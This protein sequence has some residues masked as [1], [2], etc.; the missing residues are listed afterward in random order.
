MRLLSFLLL[1]LL[2]AFSLVLA[3]DSSAENSTA[4]ANPLAALPVCAQKCLASAVANSTCNPNDVKCTC[5][6]AS[7]QESSAICIAG[8]CTVRE[9]LTTK[10]ATS[11][12]CGVPV[13]NKTPIFA[14]VTIVL[15]VIAGFIV[16]LRIGSKIGL[17]LG[18]AS[19]DYAILV[20]LACGIPSSVMNVRGTGGNGEG[21]DIWTLPF[22]MI[23]RFGVYFYT[24]EIL[25][26][27]QVMLL[28][29]TLLFFYLQIFPGPAR[30]LLWGTVVVNGIFGVSFMLLATFQC[31]PIS[32]FW[33]GWDGEHKGK[34]L[35]S[36][37]IGWANAAISIAL[38]LW[39]I[40]IPM[41]QV[42]NLNLHWKKKVGVAIMLLVGTFVTVVSIVRLQFL[43]NLGS[44][45]NPTFD[46]VDVSIW[47]T[48]EINTGI[49]CTCLPSIRLFLIRLF[50]V[51]GGSS[52][53]RSGYQNYPDS[54]GKSDH[55]NSRAKTLV[56]AVKSQTRPEH[57]G[58]ELETRYEVRYS[59]E[60][61]ARLVRMQEG[62]NLKSAH[63]ASARSVNSA[64]E[65]SL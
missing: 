23:T 62:H 41:W 8:A 35:N 5:E 9:S 54:Y 25:Y 27:A 20:T 65:V 61:E 59:D 64:S 49:I 34:C 50:P 29:M 21:K 52:H 48:V 1:A 38:D 32:F 31:T 37:A 36:N 44:S 2:G 33:D 30:K 63:E 22:D 26:F 28:K 39:M 16:V 13:R 57:N 15:G 51:L 18:L 58:I 45:A 4:A 19:D 43:V 12:L 55:A 24:L 47:S 11:T 10:N 14:N 6:S 42:R 40:A 46:Q 53:K 3:A 7:I 17:R 56:S 60:D